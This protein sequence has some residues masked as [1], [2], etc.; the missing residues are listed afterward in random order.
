MPAPQERQ[1]DIGIKEIQ[2]VH[3]SAH[4]SGLPVVL[5]KQ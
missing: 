1:P 5:G 3:R 2:R 4:S